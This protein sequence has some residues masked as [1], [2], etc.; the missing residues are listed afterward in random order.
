[1]RSIAR[2]KYARD[3]LTAKFDSIYVFYETRNVS[4]C[5][6]YRNIRGILFFRSDKIRGFAFSLVCIA[7]I[8]LGGSVMTRIS[9]N[10]IFVIRFFSG[11]RYSLFLFLNLLYGR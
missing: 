11:A 4:L 2:D 5:D 9:L 8:A 3:R 10:T 6:T 1:M 7:V